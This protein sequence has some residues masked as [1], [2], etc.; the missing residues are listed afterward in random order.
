[1]KVST[2]I[3]TD[4]V[5]YGPIVSTHRP[6]DEVRIAEDPNSSIKLV[7]VGNR[8]AGYLDSIT[9]PE[10]TSYSPLKDSRYKLTLRKSEKP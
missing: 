1:M 7:F 4:E 8:F 3:N 10:P 9:G 2:V 5:V 6:D